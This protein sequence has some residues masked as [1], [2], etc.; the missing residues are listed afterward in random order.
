MRLN[1]LLW[2]DQHCQEWFLCTKL[3][4]KTLGLS[5][6]AKKRERK[7]GGFRGR[8][9][10]GRRMEGK[11]K[12]RKKVESQEGK[13][14]QERKK[15]SQERMEGRPLALHVARVQYW[16][17][18]T[19]SPNPTRSNFWCRAR[20]KNWE[21]LGVTHSKIKKLKNLRYFLKIC[22]I[23]WLLLLVCNL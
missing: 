7:K 8:R 11:N 5:S 1:S 14:D 15:R 19:F 10:K 3:V 9:E 18:H 17:S 23:K 21:P 13:K 22:V 2:C 20:N 12:V 4:V 16:T 6:V